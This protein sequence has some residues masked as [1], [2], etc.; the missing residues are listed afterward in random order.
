MH[1]IN[2]MR[3]FWVSFLF[4][5][6]LFSTCFASGQ[7]EKNLDL[8][9]PRN[10]WIEYTEQN[11]IINWDSV[12]GSIGYN[13]YRSFTKNTDK[14][15]MEKLNQKLITSGPRFV[16][17]WRFDQGKRER[18]VK[19]YHHFISV[20]SLFNVDGDTLESALSELVS[21]NY[22]SG[23]DDMTSKKRIKKVFINEQ[24]S[25]YLPVQSLSN[26]KNA[27]IKFMTGPGIFLMKVLRD[28]L[29]FQEIG[30]CVPVSTIA[31]KLLYHWGLHA[32]KAEGVFIEEFH[33]FIVINIE[34]VEYILDFTADQ[35]VPGVSPVIVARDLCFINSKGTLDKSGIPIYQ[36]EK[37]FPGPSELN[38]TEKSRIYH[39]IY[40]TVFKKYFE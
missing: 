14:E 3:K 21:N 17:I 1:T 38:N 22:F 9:I 32:M 29:N 26:K 37:V 4:F 10:V 34:N 40:D 15:D 39:H 23:F 18:S 8:Q 36:I 19:G 27:F 25:G 16:F 5:F 13:V 31:L 20:T 24:K 35:F 28:S 30:A 2:I 6:P 11:L 33:T 7:K 12:G